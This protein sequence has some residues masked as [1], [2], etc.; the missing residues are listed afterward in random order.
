[1]TRQL[2]S[3]FTVK[4]HCPLTDVRLAFGDQEELERAAER[5]PL[6]L[7]VLPP[8]P[9]PLREATSGTCAKPECSRLTFEM[10]ASVS[11][12]LCD[13]DATMVRPGSVSENSGSHTVTLSSHSGSCR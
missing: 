12:V 5:L 6:R 3:D 4:S 2:G 1:V 9:S 10:K 11:G 7:H 8:Q 13:A